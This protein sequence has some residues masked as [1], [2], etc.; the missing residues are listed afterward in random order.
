MSMSAVQGC[1]PAQSRKLSIWLDH[2]GA[3]RQGRRGEPGSPGTGKRRC[4]SKCSG[5]LLVANKR[6]RTNIAGAGNQTALKEADDALVLQLWLG[7]VQVAP[8]RRQLR[9]IQRLDMEVGPLDCVLKRAPPREL[10]LGSLRSTAHQAS[11]LKCEGKAKRVMPLGSVG[12][13]IARP[14]PSILTQASQARFEL[15]CSRCLK[16]PVQ[17]K[18]PMQKTA[19]V[20]VTMHDQLLM[21]AP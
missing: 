14:H 8:P 17:Q 10:L 19:H 5:V 9:C 2:R 15:L 7:I 11:C 4:L 18:S 20:N 21:A 16:C 13:T 3:H 6:A 1:H 12:V